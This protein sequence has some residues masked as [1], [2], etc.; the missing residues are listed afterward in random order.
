[1]SMALVRGINPASWESKLDGVGS[2]NIRSKF[3]KVKPFPT[4]ACKTTS[5]TLQSGRKSRCTKYYEVI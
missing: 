1:M 5:R 4:S 3:F 2:M